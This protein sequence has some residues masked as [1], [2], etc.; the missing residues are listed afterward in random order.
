MT[1]LPCEICGNKTAYSAIDYCESCYTRPDSS[2]WTQSPKARREFETY[3][4]IT[5]S[6]KLTE[7]IYL[8]TVGAK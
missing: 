4:G 6:R 3:L 8:M 7:R 2:Y 1:L 5:S